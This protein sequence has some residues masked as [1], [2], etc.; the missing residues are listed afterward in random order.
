MRPESNAPVYTISVVA[1]LYGLHEQTLRLYER[2]GLLSPARV[3]GRTRMYSQDDLE[4]LEQI[5]YLIREK[6]INLEGVRVIMEIEQ[7]PE[8]TIARL[9]IHTYSNHPQNLIE[10][11]DENDPQQ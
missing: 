11:E 2:R 9:R 1:K 7:N 8:Q 4:T 10:E 5:V 6:G 3:S